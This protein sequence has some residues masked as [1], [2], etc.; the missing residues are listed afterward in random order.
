MRIATRKPLN[1]IFHADCGEV[2]TN[3]IRRPTSVAARRSRKCAADPRFAVGGFHKC[4]LFSTGNVSCWGNNSYVSGSRPLKV[5]TIGWRAG[6]L[7]FLE[8]WL[9]NHGPSQPRLLCVN[10]HEEQG[11]LTNKGRAWAK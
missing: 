4:A 10:G 9:K 1:D 7:H 8:F 2:R 6:E 3:R 11:A 5:L